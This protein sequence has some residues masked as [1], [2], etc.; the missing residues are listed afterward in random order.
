MLGTISKLTEVKDNLQIRRKF[1]KLTGNKTLWWFVIHCQEEILC[2]LDAEWEKVKLQ[3][4]WTLQ[5]CYKPSNEEEQPR[6]DS[7]MQTQLQST[8]LPSLPKSQHDHKHQT[9][10][11]GTT[12]LDADP[13]NLIEPAETTPSNPAHEESNSTDPFLGKESPHPPTPH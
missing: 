11:N 5:K 12:M 13:S 6:T 9:D 8:T 7:D 10:G 1:K 4:G 2:K 3:T